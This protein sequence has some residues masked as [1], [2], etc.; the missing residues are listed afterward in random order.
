MAKI[1]NS[2]KFVKSDAE[3]NNNK[4]WQYDVYDDGT[5][6][7]QWGRIG[8]SLQ[9]QRVPFSQ[10]VLD[11]KIKEKTQPWN[12]KKGGYKEITI[13]A[14]PTGPSGPTGSVKHVKDAAIRDIAGADP[15]LSALV[16]RLAEA[17]K[18][19]IQV[20]TGGQMDI[21]LSTGIISTPVG[22]VSKT[23]VEQARTI[24]LD[25]LVPLVKVA[26][27]DDPKY[28]RALSDYLMLVPQRV[29][30]NNWHRSFIPDN[31]GI[32]RQSS[33]LDQLESSIELVEQRMSV[34]T[35]ASQVSTPIARAF[36]VRLELM[37]SKDTDWVKIC[38]LYED[39]K[40]TNHASHKLKPMRGFR[41]TLPHM[42]AAYEL[43]GAKMI[44]QWQL[45]HG[46]R[47]FNLL[48]IMKRGF[49]LPKQLSSLNITGAMFSDGIYFSDQ[50]TKSLNYSYG[51]WGS[52]NTESGCFMFVVDVAMGKY[53]VPSGPR[54][55]PPPA[56]YDSY[57]A[58]GRESGV[59]NNEMIIFRTSQA[60]ITHLI[61][62]GSP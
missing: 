23:N 60:N 24:L 5:M 14:A 15:I 10:S 28:K 44:N 4:V 39:G 43:D 6:H 36:D 51:Y 27:F 37:D 41:V 46:S 59:L 55:E 26:G 22:V 52:G 56:G 1:V 32:A 34:A 7:I 49:V 57:F 47:I 58:K 62:F 40:N 20:A 19:E 2:Q 3:A 54:R 42:K 18:H 8:D 33:L 50:S 35:A 17:N 61:E 53:Y 21:D 12:G 29:A 13:M 48:S 45:W 38:K 9:E 11:K 16:Q 30:K 31:T 25:S